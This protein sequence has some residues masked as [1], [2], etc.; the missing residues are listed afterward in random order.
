LIPG[1]TENVRNKGHWGTGDLEIHIKSIDD[2]E[3][4]KLLIDRAYNEN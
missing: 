2:F 3:K 4:A 1:F